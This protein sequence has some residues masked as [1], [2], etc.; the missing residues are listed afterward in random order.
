MSWSQIFHCGVVPSD[1]TDNQR[2]AIKNLI[3]LA[4]ERLWIG[5]AHPLEPP[6]HD[7]FTQDC[8]EKAIHHGRLS[9]QIAK[10]LI[11]IDETTQLHTD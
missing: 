4:E 7:T 6:V 2:T 11:G 1:L 8:S 5:E 3:M 10:D 9:I